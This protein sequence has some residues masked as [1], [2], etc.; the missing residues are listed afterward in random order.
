LEV[1]IRW[2]GRFAAV[3][4]DGDHMMPVDHWASGAVTSATIIPETR[5]GSRR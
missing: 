1:A 5:C 2:S 3:R 4:A